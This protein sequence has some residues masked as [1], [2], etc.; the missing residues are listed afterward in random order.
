MSN[1]FTVVTGRCALL[2]LLHCFIAHQGD[3]DN[4]PTASPLLLPAR[5]FGGCFFWRREAQR[6]SREAD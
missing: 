4:S 1:A 2:S 3:S 5:R 6:G